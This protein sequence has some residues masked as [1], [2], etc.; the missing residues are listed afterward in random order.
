M[1]RGIT[2]LVHAWL[3]LD[4]F[5][6]S[7][8]TGESGSSLTTTI[9][10]QSFIGLLFAAFL[11]PEEGVSQTEAYLAANLSISTL[12]VGILLLG[13]PKRHKRATA[14]RLL[15]RTS[16][17]PATALTLAR[18]MHG[19][20]YL[21][22]V[23]TGMAIPPA[24][25][26]YWVCGHQLWVVPVYLCMASLCAGL[27]AGL[28]ACINQV[29]LLFMGVVRA[30]L[31]V[32]SLK[33]LLLGGGFVGIALCMPKLSGSAADL[34]LGPGSAQAWPPYWAGK[35]LAE[36]SS[37]LGALALLCALGVTLYLLATVLAALGR[38]QRQTP[39]MRPGVLAHLDRHLAK[40]GPLLGMTRFISTMLYRSPGYRARVLP[41]FGMPIAMILLSMLG[42][43]DGKGHALLLGMTL[44][45]PAIFLPFLVTFLPISDHENS[46][47]VFHTSPHIQPRLYRSASLLSLSSHLLIPLFGLAWL[48][49]SFTS[50]GE[51]P[52]LCFAFSLSTFSLALA[53][54]TAEFCLRRLHSIPFTQDLDSKDKGADFGGMMGIAAVLSLLGGGFS[55]LAASPW[56]LALGL[57]CLG[58]AA[59]RLRAA[60]LQANVEYP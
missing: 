32:S 8:K 47:W 27:L 43:Q 13:D 50:G 42:S 29:S 53:I 55:L 6:H 38:R 51:W 16:P 48:C 23:T 10:A 4:F 24:I 26:A 57:A 20:F 52:K 1:K 54:L 39:P 59:S 15:V 7:R 49:L 36:P 12:L 35:F 58:F 44:Q 14:D 25:L 46:S 34:P 21:C 33:T 22:L 11:L 41:L 31:V 56:G 40:Q 18:A 2:S 5:G 30:Q 3:V 9:F 37:N 28:L 19:G 60:R 17:L 45:F